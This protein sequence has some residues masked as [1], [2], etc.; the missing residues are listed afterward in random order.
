[1]NELT[2]QTYNAIVEEVQAAKTEMYFQ[3]NV[4]K[5]E[6]SHSIGEIIRRHATDEKITP[7]LTRLAGD[8]G[9]SERSLWRCV[10][11]YDLAPEEGGHQ[12]LLDQHGKDI[13]V[14][15][16]ISPPKGENEAERELCPHCKRPMPKS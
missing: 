13:T 3:A 4:L 2:T 6:W 14:S 10:Q 11:V 9:M 15:K 12:K 7:L 8:V 16:L 1:M 5:I